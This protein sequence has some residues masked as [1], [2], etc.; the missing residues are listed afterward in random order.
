MGDFPMLSDGTIP[1]V[2]QRVLTPDGPG[3]IAW[4][5]SVDVG[6]GR[7][8]RKDW[9]STVALDEGPAKRYDVSLL[10]PEED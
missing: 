4:T 8:K 5:M 9:V 10:A 7:S 6:E 2:E 1:R 3:R